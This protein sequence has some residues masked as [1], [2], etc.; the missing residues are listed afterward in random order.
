MALAPTTDASF[1]PELKQM[2]VAEA[3]FRRAEAAAL[4]RIEEK[5]SRFIAGVNP[6]LLFTVHCSM[7]WLDI[8]R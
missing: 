7:F 6:T 2:V 3:R 8:P 4:R 5:A 1:T